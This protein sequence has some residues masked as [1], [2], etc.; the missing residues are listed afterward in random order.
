[1]F[2]SVC[3]SEAARKLLLFARKVGARKQSVKSPTRAE[4]NEQREALGSQRGARLDH[5]RPTS[6]TMARPLLSRQSA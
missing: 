5:D 6:Q 4:S 2:T 3:E 1:M